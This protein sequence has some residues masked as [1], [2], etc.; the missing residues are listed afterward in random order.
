MHRLLQK[1]IGRYLGES[2]RPDEA[3]ASFLEQVSS[4]YDEVDVEQRLLKNALSRQSSK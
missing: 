1:Q 3:F 4:R 2:F